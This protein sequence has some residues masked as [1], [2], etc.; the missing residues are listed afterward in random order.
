MLLM[1][2]N[3]NSILWLQG[4]VEE[5]KPNKIRTLQG[6]TQRKKTKNIGKNQ[7]GE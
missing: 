5:V 4:N 2:A 6:Q 3:I 1:C 7:R